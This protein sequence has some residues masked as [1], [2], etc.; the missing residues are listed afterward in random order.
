MDRLE[1]SVLGSKGDVYNVAFERTGENLNAFCTCQAGQ[2][3]VYCK[4]RFSLMDG[5]YENIISE[6]AS[7]LEKLKSMVKGTDVEA[8]YLA[9]IE[10]DRNYELAKKNLNIARVKLA[11]AMYR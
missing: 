7:D 4:H 11:R 5:E 1:F 10:A 3:G 6:N 8:A 9:V 2:N